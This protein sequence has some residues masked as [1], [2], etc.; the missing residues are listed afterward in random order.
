[1]AEARVERRLAAILAADVAGYSRLMGVDEEGTLAALKAYRREVIDPKIAEHRGRIVKTTGDGALIEFASAVD[2]V[3]CAIEI[4]RAMAERNVAIPEDHR[5][6]FRIG[7]NVG[8]VIIDDGDIYGDGVNIAARVETLANPGGICLSDNAYQQIKGKLALDVNDMGE[9]PLKNIAQPVRVYGVR[10]DG[11]PARPVLTLP[12]K[13]SIAVLAFTNM[14][15]DPEQE[16]FADGIAEDIITALSRCNALFVI[17][18]NSSFTFKGKTIHVRQVGR[19]LGVR[20][21]LEGSV[22]RSGFRLRVTGQLIEAESGNHIWADHFDGDM[23]DVFDFQDRITESVVA[24]IEPNLQLAEI[25]RLK[26]KPA[27]NLDAYDLL[28]RAQQLEYKFTEESIADAI[29]FLEQALVIDP[30]YAQAMALA[31]CCYAERRQQGWAKDLALEAAEGM[32]LAMRAVELGKDDANVLWMA[33]YAARQ[34]AMD[35]QLAK[36]LAYRSLLLNPNSAIALAITG[37]I[38]AILANPAKAL[39][40]LHRANRLSPRDPKGWFITTGLG[41]S[42]FFAGQFDEA[43]A[44]C[45]KALAQNPRFALA[46]RIL[47]ASLAKLGQRDRAKEAVRELL[48]IEPQL[49]ISS[50]RARTLAME[51]SVWIMFSDGLRLAGLPE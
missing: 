21:V 43:A 17:A 39:E 2:A 14:S 33:A 40:H 6:E 1:M 7:I 50:L 26:R 45:K 30:D 41:M 31:A 18:R 23:S 38:E 36:E 8:D 12:D 3:R 47:A 28:L 37:W 42:H 32:R 49:T 9:Q 4:Q 24:A 51:E 46:F 19:E 25:E 11:S 48:K 13:P 15:G 16:Y 20:Y 22:R 27:T 5:I 44:W 10:L 34:L 35:G 29:R